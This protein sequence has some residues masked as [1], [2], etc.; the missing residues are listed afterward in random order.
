MKTKRLLEKIAELLSPEA[1]R[2]KREIAALEKLCKKLK[3]KEEELAGKVKEAGDDAKR[4]KLRKKIV[5]LAAQREKGEKILADL[6]DPEAQK[7][8]KEKKAA[9]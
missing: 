5:L 6:K 2:K 1:R 9:S 7:A 8:K 4:A 3:E